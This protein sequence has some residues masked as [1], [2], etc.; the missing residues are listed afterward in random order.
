MKEFDTLL[1]VEIDLGI[2]KIPFECLEGI[3][4][5]GFEVSILED[6]IEEP[7]VEKLKKDN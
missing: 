3:K 2:Q 1:E 5:S 4:L 6:L 7:K